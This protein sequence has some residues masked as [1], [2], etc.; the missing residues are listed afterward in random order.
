MAAAPTVTISIAVCSRSRS[1][2]KRGAADSS[3]GREEVGT[4][5]HPR[6]HSR[7]AKLLNRAVTVEG[8][9]PIEIEEGGG[10]R[11]DT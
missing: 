1:D 10:C 7:C 11:E 8:G 4:Q 5:S 3:E 6:G 2:N 9:E